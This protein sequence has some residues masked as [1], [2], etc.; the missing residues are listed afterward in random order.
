[1]TIRF[2]EA[3]LIDQDS[4]FIDCFICC[5][6][7]NRWSMLEILRVWSKLIKLIKNGHPW[8]S[9]LAPINWL[10]MDMYGSYFVMPHNTRM[11]SCK[12]STGS[13]DLFPRNHFAYGAPLGRPLHRS[14]CRR[15]C[16]RWAPCQDS[17]VDGDDGKT[18]HNHLLWRLRSLCGG[19]VAAS[20]RNA[21]VL[22]E[23]APQT[24]LWPSVGGH[25]HRVR[26]AP[27]PR[28]TLHR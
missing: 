13:T 11:V 4:G 3:R 27:L 19:Q 5:H 22:Y 12:K 8:T 10:C 25:G 28:W 16:Q 1:M 20:L 2:L 15:S 24:W 7:Y 17:S 9:I 14:R 18:G 21:M 26:Q 6:D 23:S